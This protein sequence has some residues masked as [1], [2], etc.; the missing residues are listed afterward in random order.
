LLRF[1]PSFSKKGTFDNVERWLK[2]LRD[3]AEAG[4]VV[5][6]VG[7][8]SDLKHLRTVTTEEAMQFAK[9]NN[10]VTGVPLDASPPSHMDLFSNMWFDS[11]VVGL[12]P[13][14]VLSP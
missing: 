4:I 6:L 2:E 14:L 3:H 11:D 12:V 1:V 8:K 7:N 5:M 13:R 9:D 10:L